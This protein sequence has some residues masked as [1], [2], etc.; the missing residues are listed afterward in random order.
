MTQR[1][2]CILADPP[3]RYRDRAT[4]GAA[5][6]HYPTMSVEELCALPVAALA[7]DD[8]HL[9][10]WV[11]NQMLADG[12]AARVA[13][14]WGF[15]PKTVVTWCKVVRGGH[16]PRLGV[17]HYLRN[18]TEHMLFAVRGRLRPLRR[19]VPTWFLAPVGRHSEK[20]EA[21]YAIIEAVSPG[22][23][24]ELFARRRRNGWAV[25]GNEVDSDITLHGMAA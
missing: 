11:T 9:W 6:R 10:L 22:P 23:R 18:A 16:G 25:W 15:E 2:R 8:A 17:G 20:P 21:A 7:E 1:F 3:W 24:L 19:D 12:T 14:A 13:Q 4:R 5:E